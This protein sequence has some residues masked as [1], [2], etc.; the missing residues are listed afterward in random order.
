VTDVLTFDLKG[1]RESVLAKPRFVFSP[2]G[3]W[4]CYT[5]LSTGSSKAGPRSSSAHLRFGRKI[6]TGNG[7]FTVW[8]DRG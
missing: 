4:I 5:T 8:T 2:D 1:R 7:N 3:R 6:L